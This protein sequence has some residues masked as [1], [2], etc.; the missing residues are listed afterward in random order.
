MTSK[1]SLRSRPADLHLSFDLTLCAKTPR[2]LR[3]SFAHQLKT[4]IR[5]AYWAGHLER[6]FA[7]ELW[8]SLPVPGRA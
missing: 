7:E 1:K 3:E 8:R 5:D 6:P 2:G 4:S